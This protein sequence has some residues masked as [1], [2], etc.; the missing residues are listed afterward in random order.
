MQYKLTLWPQTE[1]EM[2][3][4]LRIWI[5]A[6]T[7]IIWVTILIHLTRFQ[8][9]HFDLSPFEVMGTNYIESLIGLTCLVIG[10]ALVPKD[11]D[12]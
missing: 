11:K 2:N 1:K 6:I 10:F 12:I 8:I 3:E 4:N 7:L 9:D 5:V